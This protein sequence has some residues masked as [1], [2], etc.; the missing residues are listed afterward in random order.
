MPLTKIDIKYN[1]ETNDLGQCTIEIDDHQVNELLQHFQP[2]FGEELKRAS[3]STKND[4]TVIS[5]LAPKSK[6]MRLEKV[7]YQAKEAM[8]RLN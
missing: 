1:K 7:I 2:L 5:F 8:A 6:I 3:F 4:Q